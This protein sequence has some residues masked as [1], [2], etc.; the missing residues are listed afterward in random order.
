[1]HIRRIRIRNF[2]RLRDAVVIEGLGPGLTVIAGENEEGKSTVLAALQAAFFNRHRL[3]GDAA[4]AMQPFGSALRP[5]ITIDFDLN[6]DRYTLFKAFCQNP[7]ARIEGPTGHWSGDAA[8]ERLQA[9]L[10]FEPP[11]KGA[12]KGEHRGIWGL[13]WVEQGTAFARPELSVQGRRTVEAALE[14]EVGQVLGGSRAS[15]LLAAIENRYA[16]FFTPKTGRPTGDY[17]TALDEVPRLEGERA[18]LAQQL[19]DYE[20]KM[21]VLTQLRDRVAQHDRDGS[22]EKARRALAE[23]QQQEAALEQL[24]TALNEAE[25]EE[26]LAKAARDAVQ[27]AWAVRQGKIDALRKLVEQEAL[28]ATTLG[29]KAEALKA[30]EAEKAARQAAYD[31]AKAAQSTA[32]AVLEASDRTLQR[33]RVAAELNA[34]RER[35]HKAEKAQQE[36]DRLRAE[37][38]AIAVDD[39]AMQELRDLA[40]EAERA[41]IKLEA[42]ATR[43]TFKPEGSSGVRRDDGEVVESGAPLL[44]TKPTGFTLE[45]FGKLLIEPGGEELAPLRQAAGR[46]AEALTTA[47]QRLG[48]ASLDGAEAQHNERLDR[49][50]RAREQQAIVSANA[51]EGLAALRQQVELTASELAE[52]SRGATGPLLAVPEAETGRREARQK[53]EGAKSAFERAA[54]DLKTAQTAY[55][56]ARE[57]WLTADVNRNSAAQQR[58]LAE[59]ALATDRSAAP[60][61][62]LRANLQAA[63]VRHRG[64]Q[65]ALN[66][67]RA[68]VEAAKPAEVRRELA[69]REEAL[70]RLQQQIKEAKEEILALE[71]ELRGMGHLGLGERLAATEGELER[72]RARAARLQREAKAIKL[73]LETLTAAK[74]EA[75]EAF[76]S[77]VLQRLKPHLAVLFPQS[78]IRLTQQ[79]LVVSHLHQDGVDV[80]FEH[81]SLGTRE[82]LSV[83][84]RL[85]FAEFLRENGRPAAVILDEALAYADDQRFDR[86][87]HVLHRAANRLQVIV[88]TCRERDYTN[89]G[90]PIIRLADC[91]GE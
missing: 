71:G 72:A 58:E 15:A 13:F 34:L 66:A 9:L 35:L 47:F 61:E 62:T 57:A 26:K 39:V 65:D 10:G 17:K 3:T 73:L 63:L 32:Q 4:R 23:A 45:G 41:R 50:S 87:R 53:Y 46:T 36:H 14:D 31:E 18:A 68:A 2:R 27:G 76:I 20:Q 78:E 19:R 59:R 81:L 25:T 84:A 79:D 55:T 54:T 11:G 28:S 51:A 83:L 60:D 86:M 24:E 37:A 5:E 52:L 33:A 69:A 88:L 75:K 40:R 42:I 30:A 77:P 16:A 85:A 48:V 6:G 29:E 89:F 7:E 67:C 49:L 70:N 43:V 91:R 22:L 64:A 74:Q 38:K 56:R 1:M 21:D 12:A 80:P 82:Q 90:A 44:L 8:E